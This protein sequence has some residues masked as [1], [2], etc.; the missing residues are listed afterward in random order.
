MLSEKTIQNKTGGGGGNVKGEK[1]KEQNRDDSA[2]SLRR[3]RDSN[4]WT[5]KLVNGFRDRP[6][7]PLRHLSIYISSVFWN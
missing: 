3:E 6:V 5:S 2:P 7:R 4:P 1:K